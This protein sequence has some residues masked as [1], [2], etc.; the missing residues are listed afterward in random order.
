MAQWTRCYAVDTVGNRASCV[1]TV[2]AVLRLHLFFYSYEFISMKIMSVC[3]YAPFCLLLSLYVCI[4]FVY[5]PH[6]HLYI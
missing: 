2:P 6:K 3:L 4:A 5:G 1:S